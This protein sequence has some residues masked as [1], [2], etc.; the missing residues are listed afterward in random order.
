MRRYSAERD[1]IPKYLYKY[2]PI[3]HL[4]FMSIINNYNWFSHPKSFNDPF[5]CQFD[6]CDKEVSYDEYMNLYLHS[7]YGSKLP[8]EGT[9][10]IEFPKGSIEHNQLTREFREIALDFGQHV[11]KDVTER[12]VLSLSEKFDNTTMWSHYSDNHQGICLEFC[13][14]TLVG[15]AEGVLHK[16]KYLPAG[17][18]NFNAYELYARCSNNRNFE[19]YKQIINEMVLTKSDDWE[20]ESEWRI[21][22]AEVGPV[23]FYPEAL[24][25]VYFGLRCGV[26]EKV[27]IRNIL[28]DR[29]MAFF[30]MRRKK[31]GFGI[32]AIPMSKDSIYWEQSP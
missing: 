30:Q 12:S 14:A 24:K 26:E 25:G 15:H 17:K 27:A 29:R 20:Y 6:I 4:T 5:D 23:G 11:K 3:N 10:L 2:R 31:S 8:K 18:I 13:P 22:H 7:K 19:Q 9:V 21:V 1:M 16:V 32:E 28:F